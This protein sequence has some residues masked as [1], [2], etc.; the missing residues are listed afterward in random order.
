MT[1]TREREESVI[2]MLSIVNDTWPVITRIHKN[3][4]FSHGKFLKGLRFRKKD[5]SKEITMENTHL[6]NTN[7][8]I[9]K[10]S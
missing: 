4:F 3:H 5:Q 1:I 6:K 10:P 2:A 7:S 8:I 9:L